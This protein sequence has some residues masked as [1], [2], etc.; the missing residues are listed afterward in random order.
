MI[1]KWIRQR[2]SNTMKKG[3]GNELAQTISVINTLSLMFN[4]VMCLDTQELLVLE[5][6]FKSV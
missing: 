1:V 6:E 5:Q 4:S 2:N 3:E